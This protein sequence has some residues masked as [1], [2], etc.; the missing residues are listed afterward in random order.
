MKIASRLVLLA[1][2]GGLG[3]WLWTVLFPNPEKVV[4]GRISSL[5]ATATVSA[6]AGAITRATKVSNFIGYFSTDAV[7]NYDLPG[8]G[9]HTLSGLDEIRETAAGGFAGVS[10]LKVQFQDATARASPDKQ[11]AEVSCTAQVSTGDS[12]DFGIQELRIQFKK[13]GGDWLI[14]RV[15]TVKTL[16]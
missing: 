6:G 10:S 14:T 8:I 4:L 5:A 7:I 1:I 13:T 12:K 11:S 3:F 16:Q 15:E 9:A 2:L